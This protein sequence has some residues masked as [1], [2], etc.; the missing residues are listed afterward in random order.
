MTSAPEGRNRLPVNPA[1][2]TGTPAPDNTLAAPPAITAEQMVAAFEDVL[3]EIY[4]NAL[5]SVVYIRVPTRVSESL[6]GMSGIPDELLWSAGSGFVWD[7]QG[8]IVTNHHVVEEAIGE[9]D[10][11]TVIFADST[12]AKGTVVG[13]DPHSDLAVIK[14]EEGAWDLQPATL[15]DSSEVRVGQLTVAIG[16]PF[17]QQF[18]MTSGIVSAVGRNITGQARS[19]FPK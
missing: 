19:L 5:P 18:T 4:E 12:W 16:A 3:Y 15:G 17:G 6:R 14:L 1:T 7:D 9:S 11:V 8:H 13:S 10:V 2:P